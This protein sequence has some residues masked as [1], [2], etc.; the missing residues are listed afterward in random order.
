MRRLRLPGGVPG[1][2]PHVG[3]AERAGGAAGAA[4]APLPPAPARAALHAQ[5]AH[6]GGGR[7]HVSQPAVELEMMKL[8]EA[9]FGR[10]GAARLQ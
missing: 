10:N 7:P 3:V 6:Q 8:L 1:D 9:S 2:V 5:P 4:R